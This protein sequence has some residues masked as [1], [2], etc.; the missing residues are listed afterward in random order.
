MAA[1]EALQRSV[2]L[3]NSR[4]HEYATVSSLLHALVEEPRCDATKTLQATGV[5]LRKLRHSLAHFTPADGDGGRQMSANG[6]HKEVTK[7]N[8]GPALKVDSPPAGK[9]CYMVGDDYFVQLYSRVLIRRKGA[10]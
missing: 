3:S 8:D 4:K 10:G 6:D 2:I 7:L 9:T 1:Q 5:N